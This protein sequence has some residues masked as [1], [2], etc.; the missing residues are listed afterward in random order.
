MPSL[1]SAKS[2]KERKKPDKK[3]VMFYIPN[4]INR[5]GFFPGEEQ[6]Q[7][8]GFVGGFNADKTKQQK[9]VENKA[10][11][12]P[13]EF[14]SSMQPL[15]EHANDITLVT[16]MERTFK[17]GQDVHAQGASCYLTSVSPEQATEKG[18]RYPNGR[19]LDQVIGDH[20]GNLGSSLIEQAVHTGTGIEN[21]GHLDVCFHGVC[22][23]WSRY[24]GRLQN[25]IISI[26]SDENGDG[27]EDSDQYGDSLFH[28][29][30]LRDSK[31]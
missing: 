24:R 25:R 18:W 23:C 3:M 5:R 9:R 15:R 12:Y 6:A 26:H 27:C 11:I 17:N 30:K 29:K 1:A 19:S 10:G 22:D 2:L 16:G 14:S 31:R 8:P 7:L 21:E 4:G 13:L 20:V 28:F